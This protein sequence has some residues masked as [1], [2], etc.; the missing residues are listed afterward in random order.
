MTRVFDIVVAVL[1]LVFLSPLLAVI[2][3]AVRLTSRGPVIYRARR[4][5][6]DGHLFDLY[7]FRSMYAATSSGAAIT[8]AGD[9]RVT[10]L[11]RILRAWK[12]DE[13]PQLLNVLRGEMSVV[14]PRPEDPRY[15][16]LYDDEQRQ[17]LRVRPGITSAAS[18]LYRD[19]ESTLTAEDW[20]RQYVSEV[21]PAKLRIDLDYLRRRSI[22]SDMALIVKTALGVLRIGSGRKS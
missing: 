20:E 16:A 10:P 22:R 1:S 21:M 4:V 12:V 8:R 9:P 19:E 3:L 6:R 18:L 11:G 15:T 7:K 17:V 5:G 13:L 2:A 14:G